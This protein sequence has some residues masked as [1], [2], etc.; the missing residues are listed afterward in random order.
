MKTIVP[1]QMTAVL[2]F[3]GL[4]LTGQRWEE[5]PYNEWSFLQVY[6]VLLNSSW[7]ELGG[8]APA[9]ESASGFPATYRV[10]L[11]SSKPIREAFLRLASLTVRERTINVKDLSE[12]DIQMEQARLRRFLASDTGKLVTQAE[13]RYVIICMT[14]RLKLPSVS[15]G[16]LFPP[17]QHWIDLFNEERLPQDPS[18]FDSDTT[19]STNTGQHVSLMQFIPPRKSQLG[20]L[21]LFPRNLADGRPLIMAGDKKLRFKTKIKGTK[22]EATFNLKK[23]VY[24][25]NL[26]F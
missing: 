2:F 20:A 25:G 24:K 11:L 19:L 18:D 14:L 17:H 4:I 16:L 13:D 9:P 12:P 7:V 23:M 10:R 8:T 1:I 21:F 3:S 15:P 22:I 5:A 26:E 6:D